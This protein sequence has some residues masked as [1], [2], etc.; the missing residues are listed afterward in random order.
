MNDLTAKLKHLDMLQAIVTRM[1]QNSFLIKGWSITLV[2]A[3][4]GL[5]VKDGPAAMV[6][7]AMLTVL[8]FWLLDGYYLQQERIFRRRFDQV[9]LK[10]PEDI[11]FSMAL[12]PSSDK[13][14]A[15]WIKTC[16][17]MTLGVFHGALFSAILL[18]IC[19]LKR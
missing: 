17:S 16:F 3:L 4:L 9:R 7:V 11:D 8:A 2:G 15:G 18:T 5:A 19:F 1:A 10:K 12:E 6:W 13:P 14:V